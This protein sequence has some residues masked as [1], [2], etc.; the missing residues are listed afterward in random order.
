MA[1]LQMNGSCKDKWK[2]LV[3]IDPRGGQLAAVALP[4]PHATPVP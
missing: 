1:L 2:E 4:V 3:Q